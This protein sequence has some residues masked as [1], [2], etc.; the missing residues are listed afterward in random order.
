M[1]AQ[2]IVLKE[3]IHALNRIERRAQVVNLEIPLIASP[4][5]FSNKQHENE[6]LGLIIDF[7][8]ATNSTETRH[9]V[10]CFL[11][12]V[13]IMTNDLELLTD[14]FIELDPF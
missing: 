7:L 9:S 5:L 6:Q 2:K 4:K 12:S 13:L 8:S 10:N 1:T 14:K 3:T 11:I